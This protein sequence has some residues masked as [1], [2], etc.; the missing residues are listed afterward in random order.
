MRHIQVSADDY[1]F[2]CGKSGEICPEVIF[3]AHPVVEPGK[4]FLRIWRVHAYKIELR[5]FK[6]YDSAFVVVFVYSY[7]VADG[8]GLVF[9]KDGS[10]RV[11]FPVRIIPV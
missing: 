5:H 9:C 8:Y 3:P 4:F 2:L 11:S 6:G 10:S 7:A 1:S